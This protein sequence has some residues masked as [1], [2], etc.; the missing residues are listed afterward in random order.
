M[1]I[2]GFF[3]V[4]LLT[5]C[6]VFQEFV[7]VPVEVYVPVPVTCIDAHDIPG[8]VPS[9]ADELRIGDTAG[10]KIRAVL[11]EREQLRNVESELRALLITCVTD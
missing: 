6:S 3:G 10:E 11:V 9:A 8:E 1:K 2:I 7:T 5:G 4:A